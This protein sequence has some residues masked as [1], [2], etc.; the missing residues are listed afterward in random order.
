VKKPDAISPVK[1]KSIK[2]GVA[3]KGKIA[4]MGMCFCALTTSLWAQT[5][6]ERVVIPAL[7]SAEIKG[8]FTSQSD[9]KVYKGEYALSNGKSLQLS[10]FQTRMYAQIGSQTRHEIVRVGNGKFVALDKTI[11]MQLNEDDNGDING[12]MTYIDEDIQKTAGL[13]PEAA[14]ISV[15]MR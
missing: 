5:D 7:K 15:A 12:N 14:I 13:P 11:E 4:L 1:E 9:F 2:K 8:Y 10:R 3:M 6:V